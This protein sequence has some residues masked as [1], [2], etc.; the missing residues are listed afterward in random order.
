MACGGQAKQPVALAAQASASGNGMSSKKLK[1]LRYGAGERLVASQTN[2]QTTG[3]AACSSVM[4]GNAPR[5][6]PPASRSTAPF[7]FMR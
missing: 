5:P 1:E 7:M 6:Q 3:Q 4:N 2:K